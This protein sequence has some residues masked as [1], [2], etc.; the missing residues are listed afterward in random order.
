M[1]RGDQR[2]RDRAKRQAKEASK[3]K[4]K[5]REGTPQQR[6]QDDKEAL[7]AKLE[8]KKAKKVSGD[9][10]QPAVKKK[11][12]KQTSHLDDLL[13]AGLSRGQKKKK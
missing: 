10:K 7:L 6:N 12:N 9:S 2:E 8:A 1:S 3:T 11:E 5:E 13:T 4:G